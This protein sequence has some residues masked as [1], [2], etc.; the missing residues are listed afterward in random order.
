M[1]ASAPICPLK[2]AGLF[3]NQHTL[4]GAITEPTAVRRLM[5]CDGSRCAWWYRTSSAR[6]WTRGDGVE[7]LAVAAVGRCGVTQHSVGFSDPAE[8]RPIEP[9]PDD[10]ASP[11][12]STP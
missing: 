10:V 8:T 12:R 6:T 2:A 4:V 3:A 9:T 11:D 5:A 1:S 7:H